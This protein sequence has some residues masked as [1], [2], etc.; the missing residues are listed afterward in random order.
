MHEPTTASVPVRGSEKRPLVIANPAAGRGRTGRD[1]SRLV[2]AV[3]S[4]VGDVDVAAKGRRGDAA[5]LAAAAA[6]ERR[7]LVI[8]LGGD[9]TLDEIVNGL[10]DSPAAQA[11]RDS[12]GIQSS[13][14]MTAGPAAGEPGS[15][16]LLPAL[17]IVGTGTGGDFGRSLGIP[18]HLDAYLAA[19]AGGGERVVDVGWA[20][21][22]DLEG[23]PV[24]RY[25]LNVLSAGIGGL[26]DRYTA[27][28]PGFLSGRVAYAQAT[29]RAI[30]ACRRVKLDCTYTDPEG[31][32]RRVSLDGH[33]VAI[34]NGR[35][36]GG[37]MN[38]APMA[39]LDDGLL[40]VVVFQTRTRWRLVGKLRTVY[41]GTHLLEPGVHH[42]T[43]TELELRPAQPPA[44]RRPRAGLFALDVDGDA[45]GDVPVTAGV[46][47][48][49][50]RVRAPVSPG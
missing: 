28:A 7:P 41:A 11:P 39:A 24:S 40:E 49:A 14:G 17:G 12:R 35:T 27:T 20:R 33:A 6:Q 42:F 38:I 48:A 44:G 2:A 4:A 25:W 50:L 13:G 16:A 23:R 8:G 9:G 32:R 18:H 36:F 37:G 46:A 43:C 21:F 1:L 34:C 19:L 15:R 30:V 31:E 3:R 10:L 47:P 26:V 22:P 29:L 5:K 45:L